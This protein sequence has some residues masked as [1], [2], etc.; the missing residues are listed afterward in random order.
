MNTSNIQQLVAILAPVDQSS[1]SEEAFVQYCKALGAR[2]VQLLTFAEYTVDG[3]ADLFEP[4]GLTYQNVS[5][6][7]YGKPGSLTELGMAL[8]DAAMDAQP[9]AQV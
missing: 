2:A 5:N 8:Y 9:V 1:Q 4:L 6:A 3:A 7:I